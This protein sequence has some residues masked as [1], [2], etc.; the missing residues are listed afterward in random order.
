MVELRRDSRK[1]L[2]L[3]DILN[4]MCLMHVSL[5]FCDRLLFMPPVKPKVDVDLLFLIQSMTFFFPKP[6]QDVLLPK[7]NQTL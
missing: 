1:Y 4:V 6:D 5:F 3:C 2:I 7:P